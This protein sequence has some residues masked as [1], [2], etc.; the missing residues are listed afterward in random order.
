M[1]QKNYKT[2]D[3]KL[4][5]HQNKSGYVLERFLNNRNHFR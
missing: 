4:Q 1:L 3:Q 5:K 2:Q